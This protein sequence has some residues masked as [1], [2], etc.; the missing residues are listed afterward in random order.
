MYIYSKKKELVACIYKFRK[1]I[2]N[3]INLSPENELLQASIIK[4]D[5][6]FNLNRHIHT[7]VP[8]KTIGTQE[9]WIVM[10]GKLKATFYE[11][12]KTKIC[13]KILK[14]GDISI[15]FRGGHKFETLEKNTI[16]YEIKNGPYIKDKD[17]KKF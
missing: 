12:D 14:K 4:F 10:E 5:K 3:R 7:K 16:I 9:I 1:K 11:T 15:L 17:L 8:R 6:Q 13:S 2:N